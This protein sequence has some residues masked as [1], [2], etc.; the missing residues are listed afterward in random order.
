VNPDALVPPVSL[1]LDAVAAAEPSEVW[2]R[3]RIAAAA[4]ATELRR[5]HQELE[6]DLDR[7]R[8]KAA[9]AR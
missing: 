1:D 8:G 5:G 7:L 6:V 4:R 9:T 3:L 2:E